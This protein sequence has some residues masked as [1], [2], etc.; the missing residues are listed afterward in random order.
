MN[1]PNITTR[2]NAWIE[3]ARH[4][5]PIDSAAIHVCVTLSINGIEVGSNFSS[6]PFREMPY[7]TTDAE[8]HETGFWAEMVAE[9]KAKA[10]GQAESLLGV[11]KDTAA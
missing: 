5:A 11:L 2:V 3:T 1:N 6:R 7:V 9:A 10:M 4:A 8:L